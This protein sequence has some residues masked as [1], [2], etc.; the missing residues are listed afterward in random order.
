MSAPLEKC[1]PKESPDRCPQCGSPDPG[2]KHPP[3]YEKE[4]EFHR[5]APGLREKIMTQLPP[6]LRRLMRCPFCGHETE[7]QCIGTVYCGPHKVADTYF[8]AR[9]M[10]EV[11]EP[12]R[13]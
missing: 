13:G 6:D 8:P 7:T 3:C 9:A 10:Q 1:V 4:N 11:K 12:P 2:W 5:E